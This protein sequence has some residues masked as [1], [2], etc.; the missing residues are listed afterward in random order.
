MDHQL[1]GFAARQ[2]RFVAAETDCEAVA[3]FVVGY[4]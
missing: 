4:K 2:R 1:G 3:C